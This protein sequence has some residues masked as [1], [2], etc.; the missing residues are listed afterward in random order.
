M[1]RAA[2]FISIV[3]LAGLILPAFL[4]LG[5]RLSLPS[6]KWWMLVC[7]LVWFGT[8]PVWMG[9]PRRGE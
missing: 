5:G 1:R 9:R 8:V 2:R 6:V 7:S 4:Y 3:S